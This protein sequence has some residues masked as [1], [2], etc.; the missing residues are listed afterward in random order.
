MTKFEAPNAW[1]LE[2][3]GAAFRPLPM[4]LNRQFIKIM[5]DIG[6]QS[7]TFMD[8][9]QT[10]VDALRCMTAGSVNTETFLEEASISK[11][12]HVPS[13]IAT[14]GNIGIDYH[15]DKFLYG[16]VEMAVVTK[17]RDIKYR[18]RIPVAEG[19]LNAFEGCPAI[20][21]RRTFFRPNVA[22]TLFMH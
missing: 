7:E 9:Q 6:V 16:V 22:V 1:N 14:L 3:C 21:L 10:A 20:L 12:T 2:I 15:A 11:A 4:V 18:G 8:L 5:E 19:K 13:L 17:L